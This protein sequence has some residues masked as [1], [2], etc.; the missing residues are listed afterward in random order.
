M[1]AFVSMARIGVRVSLSRSATTVATAPPY[2]AATPVTARASSST[3]RH[4]RSP[5]LAIG[6]RCSRAP[7]A[8]SQMGLRRVMGIPRSAATLSW[9]V[10]AAANRMAGLAVLT[11]RIQLSRRC[12]SGTCN[13]GS[14]MVYSRAAAAAGAAW[15]VT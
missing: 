15:S 9:I 7:T 10:V 1:T 8:I 12:G 5:S 13:S 14:M 2:V 4:Q 11:S 3:L 6:S